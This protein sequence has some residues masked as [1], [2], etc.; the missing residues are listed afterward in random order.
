MFYVSLILV[1]IIIM[2]MMSIFFKP[3]G[4]LAIKFF[5]YLESIFEED[6]DDGEEI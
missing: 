1:T 2:V 3:I 5:D 6:E 4:R